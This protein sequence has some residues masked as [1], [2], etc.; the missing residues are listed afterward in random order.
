MERM[1][2]YSMGFRVNGEPLPDPSSFT[3]AESDLDTLGKRDSTGELRRNKVAM[4]AHI[5]LEWQ[6]V[7][8]N[9]I[10]LIGNLMNK[11]DRFQF[12]YFDPIRGEQ[13]I[14]AY[15]GDREWEVTRAV[16]ISSGEWIA[17]LKVSIIQI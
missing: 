16:D 14:T 1:Y 15:C 5:K 7:Q 12:V 8:W 11:S 3:G 17:T 6:N 2:S 4:K 10:E 13:E 9:M